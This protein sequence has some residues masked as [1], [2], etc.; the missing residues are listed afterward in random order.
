M[1]VTENKVNSKSVEDGIKK[2]NILTIYYYSAKLV[3]LV[4]YIPASYTRVIGI[5]I[6]VHHWG[7]VFSVSAPRPSSSSSPAPTTGRNE[8]F[9]SHSCPVPRLSRYVAPPTA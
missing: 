6:T 4:L 2:I 1:E 7:I 3:R 5:L 8:V 9:I